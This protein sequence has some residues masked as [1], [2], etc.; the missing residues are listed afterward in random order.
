MVVYGA[1]SDC[2]SLAEL[3]T[4]I[5]RTLLQNEQHHGFEQ[6]VIKKRIK[7]YSE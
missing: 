1:F 4:D 6:D 7:I 3:C 5:S 2:Q